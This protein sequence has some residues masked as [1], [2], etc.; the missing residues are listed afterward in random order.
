M[1]ELF[2]DD[3]LP[4]FVNAI[5]SQFG[6][7]GVERGI[8]LRDATGLLSFACSD[9]SP[10]DEKRS[11]FERSLRD[12]IGA[13]AREDS[14]L[15]F[16]DDPGAKIVLEDPGKFFVQVGDIFCRLV[17]RRIVGSG[18]LSDPTDLVSEPLRF[19][20]AS[21]KGGVGRSTAIAVAASDFAARG[22]N[23]L[24]IDL[25]LEAPGLGE[26]MLDRE[27]TPKYGVTD[28]LVENGIGGVS[29]DA[30]SDFVGT[31]PLT[32]SGG[33]RIDVMPAL[34]RSSSDNPSNVLPKLARAMIEDVVG[35]EVRSVGDQISEMIDRLTRRESYDVVLIDSRA[36]LAELAAPPVLGLGAIVLLFGTAQCQTIAGYE[37]LFSGLKML[38]IRDLARG[39]S[40]DWRLLFRPVYAK[41]SLDAKVGDRFA[42][43]IYDLFAENLYDRDSTD[44]ADQNINFSVDDP[45][46]PHH[47][48]V[49]PFDPRFVDF[50]PSRNR[51]Q[52]GQAF[53]EQTYRQFLDRLDSL[54][55]DFVGTNSDGE[56]NL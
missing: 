2:F 21:L 31:S 32:T 56:P 16:A 45:D 1:A 55:A 44:S 52:L 15:L 28:Y 9:N 11:A 34:G 47:P 36:G 38:A 48:L 26:L 35:G 18:W 5:I 42:A 49:I 37:S 43:D 8:I 30:L 19:V 3:S 24:V 20:F 25:D 33:G 12:A 39:V 50:D 22:R 13:Y 46:A 6:R 27:R 54:I 40:A 17:D 41:A 14:I 29:E 53:Y 23:V 7:D 4:A 10:S 51:S